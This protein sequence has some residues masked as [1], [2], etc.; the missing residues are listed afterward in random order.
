MAALGLAVGGL[1]VLAMIA[2]SVRGWRTLPPDARVPIHHGF[3]GGYGS[4]LSKTAGLVAWPA[5]GTFIYGIYAAVFAEGLV[6]HSGGDGM[7]LIFLPL[8]LLILLKVQIGAIRVA[9]D[10][11]GPGYPRFTGKPG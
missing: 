7:I 1:L 4:Y 6:T 9:A 11:S 8:G 10:T 5:A 2:V 3:R